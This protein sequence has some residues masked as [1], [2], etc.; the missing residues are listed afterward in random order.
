MGRGSGGAPMTA[1]TPAIE[2]LLRE[3]LDRHAPPALRG[4]RLKIRYMTQVKSRPPTFALFGS[5]VEDIPEDY[6]RYLIGSLRK[7]FG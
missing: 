7:T 5:R 3:A 6:L 1:T 2:D 4:R